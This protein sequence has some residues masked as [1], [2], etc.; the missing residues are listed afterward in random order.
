MFLPTYVCV[1]LLPTCLKNGW[2]NCYQTRR[3]LLMGQWHKLIRFLVKLCSNASNWL[4]KHKNCHIFTTYW[5]INVKFGMQLRCIYPQH[6]LQTEGYILI[7]GKIA[8]NRISHAICLCVSIS[9]EYILTKFDKQKFQLLLYWHITLFEL[10][11][12]EILVIWK[13]LKSLIHSLQTTL[14]CYTIKHSI[15]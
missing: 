15:S 14:Y 10:Q 9:S 2:S 8:I 12:Q 5:A 11:S 1:C 6:I 4:L 3:I 13:I 7:F